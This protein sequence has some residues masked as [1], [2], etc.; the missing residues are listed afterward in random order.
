MVR[1]T[2][3]DG[4]RDEMD[5]PAEPGIV[6]CCCLSGATACVDDEAAVCYLKMREDK[7][8]M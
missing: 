8:R 1:S 3:D 6:E 5:K 2:V 4:I 7:R